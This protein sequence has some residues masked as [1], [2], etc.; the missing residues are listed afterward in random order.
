MR[1]TYLQPSTKEQELQVYHYGMEVCEKDHSFGPAV[2]DHF[3]IH[4]IRSGQG[5]FRIHGR[6]Y[7]LKAGQGFL[8]PPREVTFY[9]ADA[10]DPW[11]YWWVGF[12]GT[13]AQ[14]LVRGLGLNRSN[15]VVSLGS[16]S[17][18]YSLMEQL[19]DIRSGEAGSDLRV[20]GQ[21]YLLLG[22][23]QRCVGGQ[24][25]SQSRLTPQEYYI[26]QALEYI[27]RNYSRQIKITDITHYVGLN[28]SYF[29]TLFCGAMQISP[30]RYLLQYRMQ[31]A[32]E[33]LISTALSVGDIARSVGYT[34]PFTFS[35]AFKKIVGLAPN[36]YRQQRLGEN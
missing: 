17:A 36:E 19:L 32:V 35:R 10:V 2:R 6:Q 1:Q 11:E 9:Q 13:R 12:E 30:R 14:E 15:P 5:S 4:F 8:I 26:S 33:L 7:S 27:D 22:E 29:T 21:L 20:Q 28:R 24:S 16:D 23:L 3:L 25:M 31:K 34:D 18:I